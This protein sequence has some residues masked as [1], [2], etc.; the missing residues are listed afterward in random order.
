MK[1]RITSIFVFLLSVVITANLCSCQES[2]EDKAVRDAK[3]YTRRYC[4]TPVINC[5]RTDSVVFDKQKHIYTYYVT[6]SDNMDNQELID[7]HKAEII[8]MLQSAV[9]ESTSMKSYLEAGFKFQY[10]CRSASD[11]KKILLQCLI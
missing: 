10:V 6:F 11:K 4:P 2:L 5:T 7:E 3:D 8:Q 9:R 1:T